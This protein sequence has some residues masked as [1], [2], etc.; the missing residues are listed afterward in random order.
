M[1]WIALK[2]SM[3]LVVIHWDRESAWFWVGAGLVAINVAGLLSTRSSGAGRR[4][5]PDGRFPTGGLLGQSCMLGASFPKPCG[6]I[7]ISACAR[8]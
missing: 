7:R 2:A 8:R 4:W 5:R 6:E 3:A 1:R